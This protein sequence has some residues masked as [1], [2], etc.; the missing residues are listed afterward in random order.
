M[1][2]L[3][4]EDF[5]IEA[6]AKSAAMVDEFGNIHKSSRHVA[7]VRKDTNEILHYPTNNYKVIQ[8]KEVIDSFL[9]K[10]TPITNNIVLGQSHS[11]VKSEKMQVQLTFPD[12]QFND[13][14]SDVALTAYLSNSYDGSAG[15]KILWGG[16]RKI[17]TNGMI[18]GIHIMKFYA[19]HTTGASFGGL[20]HQ[21]QKVITSIPEVE[22]RINILRQLEY[23]L[24]TGEEE[25]IEEKERLQKQYGKKCADYILENYQR[26]MSQYDLLNLVTW[27][28]SHKIEASRRADYQLRAARNFK[29]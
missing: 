27:F 20:E 9:T 6:V 5:N 29:L 21:F 17:C 23:S 8:N 14:G 10:I 24:P 11:F 2:K 4:L 3:T 16:I 13:G 7:I 28:I 26:G 15:V 1:E 12:F 18:W 19:K 22:K 25:I